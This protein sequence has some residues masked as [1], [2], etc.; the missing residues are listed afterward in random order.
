MRVFWQQIIDFFDRADA[1]GKRIAVVIG[2]K[3]VQQRAVFC[4]KSRFCSGR[5]GI[6]AKI[7]VYL[8]VFQTA[9][10]NIVAAVAG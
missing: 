9:G 10:R 8:I 1:G 4:D 6:D 7:T 5:T 3:R 2:I